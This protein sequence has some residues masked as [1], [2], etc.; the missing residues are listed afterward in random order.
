MELQTPITL[1]TVAAAAASL[2][3]A[4]KRASVRAVREAIGRGSLGTIAALLTE[5]RQQQADTATAAEPPAPLPD[6]MTAA[7]NKLAGNLRQAVGEL[8]QQALNA[9]TA[10][11]EEQRAEAAAALERA[12]AEIAEAMEVADTAEKAAKTAQT[13]RDDALARAASLEGEKRAVDAENARL[14][15]ELDE[16]RGR[17]EDALQRAAAA[18]ARLTPTPTTKTARKAATK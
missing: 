2:E 13:E 6:A 1:E 10:E 16:L 5:W 8:W 12:Q 7:A 9:A 3:A 17:L 15:A 4:G 11:H 18:E 14:R